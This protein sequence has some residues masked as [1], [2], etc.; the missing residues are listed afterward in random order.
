M[1][2]IELPQHNSYA[3]VDDADYDKL[4]TYS[5]SRSGRGDVVAWDKGN[6]KLVK[7]HRLIMEAP[8]NVEVDHINRNPLDNR[9]DN[10]RYCN[11]SQNKCNRLKQHNNKSGYKGVSWHKQRKKWTVRC[12]HHGKHHYIGLFDDKEDAARAY[13]AAARRLHGDFAQLNFPDQVPPMS[14]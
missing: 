8:P 11:S 12:G 10:L 2:E 6:N 3:I 13:D 7:M 9:R 5:W 14:I 4:K 1:K